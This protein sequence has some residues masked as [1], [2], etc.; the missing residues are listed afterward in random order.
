MV[1]AG[2]AEDQVVRHALAVDDEEVALLGD[3]QALEELAEAAEGDVDDEEAQGGAIGGVDGADQRQRFTPQRH[4]GA[5]GAEES[6]AGEV[7]GEP[8][9]APCGRR[10]A[11]GAH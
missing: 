10:R 2:A 1:S 3:R 5:V 9:E 4:L 7:E 6:A 8:V 11:F